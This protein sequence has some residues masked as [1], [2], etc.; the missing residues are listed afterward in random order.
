[1]R[2]QGT[3]LV[4]TQK[5]ADV[6]SSVRFGDSDSNLLLEIMFGEGNIGRIPPPE[7]LR[8]DV[9]EALVL[10]PTI[11]DDVRNLFFCFPVYVKALNL[12]G[13]VEAPQDIETDFGNLDAV[14]LS[15][16]LFVSF[17]HLFRGDSERLE[18]DGTGEEVARDGRGYES[19]VCI[20]IDELLRRRRRRQRR[21][22]ERG[23]S[24]L[25]FRGLTSP[26]PR[27]SPPSP[28]SPPTTCLVSR[29][30]TLARPLPSPRVLAPPWLFHV[31]ARLCSRPVRSDPCINEDEM[32]CHQPATCHV[33]LCRPSTD[34]PTDRLMI[35]STCTTHHLQPPRRSSPLIGL[36]RTSSRS[37]SSPSPGH[38]RLTLI[39]SMSIVAVSLSFVQPDDQLRAMDQPA[40]RLIGRSPDTR[41]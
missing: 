28:P 16:S 13:Y 11:E 31:I 25:T 17:L 26:S 18:C 40:F 7:M 4:T 3:H 9:C 27:H 1:M 19:H 15:V 23:E 12:E 38:F 2:G 32:R 33:S 39:R 5:G 24:W 14:S 37:V 20:R 35:N 36:D 10:G 6:K 8:V 22:E 30:L 29:F 34:R 21:Y 41:S